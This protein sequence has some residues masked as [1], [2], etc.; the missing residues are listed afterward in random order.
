M[1][2][3][4]WQEC[5]SS[6]RPG[7]GSGA[8]AVAGAAVSAATTAAEPPLEALISPGGYHV[9]LPWWSLT[10]RLARPHTLHHHTTTQ[11]QALVPADRGAGTLPESQVATLIL[12]VETLLHS[13]L[14]SGV[15]PRV[16]EYQAPAVTCSVTVEDGP[17]TGGEEPP[18]PY[19]SWSRNLCL[20]YDECFPVW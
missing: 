18:P 9:L 16:A 6:G 14:V 19:I 17:S 5:G 8:R 4:R 7:C 3:Q 10:A 1:W 12:T 13:V 20:E 15:P 2:E 11:P